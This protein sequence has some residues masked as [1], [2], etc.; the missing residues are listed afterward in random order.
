MIQN[1][2]P[3]QLT[4]LFI[5]LLPIKFNYQSLLMSPFS[6]HREN[7]KF[8]PVYFVIQGGQTIS[9]GSQPQFLILLLSSN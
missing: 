3:Q 5:N 8:H 7:T 2:C 9:K 6:L 4:S 1:A